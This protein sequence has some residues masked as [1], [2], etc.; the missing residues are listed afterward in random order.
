MRYYGVLPNNGTVVVQDLIRKDGID[1][2]AGGVCMKAFAGVVDGWS[3]LI[4]GFWRTGRS[5]FELGL[6]TDRS[7]DPSCPGSCT[8]LYMY[9]NAYGSFGKRFCSDA[10][11]MIK[12]GFTEV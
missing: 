8:D 11:G 4:F 10:C 5:L 12:L 3:D 7:G 2:L 9:A 6:T 1:R